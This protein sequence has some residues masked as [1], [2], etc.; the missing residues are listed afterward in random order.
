MTNEIKIFESAE[1]GKI[2]T[3]G[4]SEEPLFC[5]A[6]VCCA[7]GITNPRNVKT[8]LDEEDVRLVDTP[9]SGGMQKI[10]FVTESGLYETIIRSDSERAKP[11]RKW[12]T[13]EVLPSIRKTGQYS[14]RDIS[15]KEL[16]VMVIQA[17]EEKERLQLEIKSKEQEIQDLGEKLQEAQPKVAYYDIILNSRSTMLIT[18]I[19]QDYGMSAKKLNKILEGMHIQHKMNGQWILYAK[20]QNMGYVH[21]KPVT[22]QHSDGRDAVKLNT[23]WTQ[24][25][26]LFLYDKLKGCGIL[27]MIERE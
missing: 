10:T 1:F 7:V 21:S 13:G 19:A 12:V 23:E 26:R 15:R 6:D 24:K 8:R 16:A 2:R 18:Q 4:T 22:I 3:A 5:L 9:T 25:G 17:E 14:L 20:Y 27:P 11:F